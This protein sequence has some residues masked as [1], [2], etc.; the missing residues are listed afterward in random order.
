MSLENPVLARTYR[1]N[2]ISKIKE[3]N[4]LLEK[5]ADLDKLEKVMQGKEK[6]YPYIDFWQIN[7]KDMEKEINAVIKSLSL[8]GK[9][10]DEKKKIKSFK[11]YLRSVKKI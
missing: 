4:E 3:K 10:E 5:P 11:N 2:I 9:K 7:R 1:N 6:G 8:K